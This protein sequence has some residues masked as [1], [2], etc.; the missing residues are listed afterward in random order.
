MS[1]Y[2]NIKVILVSNVVILHNSYNNN[3][4]I[5]AINNIK[6]DGVVLLFWRTLGDMLGDLSESQ[7]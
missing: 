5:Y 1:I 6:T 4:W 3:N 2:Y 7:C